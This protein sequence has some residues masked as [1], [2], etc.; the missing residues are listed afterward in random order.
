MLVQEQQ[1]QKQCTTVIKLRAARDM[2]INQQN[3]KCSRKLIMKEEAIPDSAVIGPC[4]RDQKLE[5][6]ASKRP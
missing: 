6:N 5:L 3:I 2:P 4:K 1:K